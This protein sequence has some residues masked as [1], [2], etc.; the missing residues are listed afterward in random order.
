MGLT[1]LSCIVV[2]IGV[3][4]CGLCI[5]LIGGGATKADMTPVLDGER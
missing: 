3:A 5:V 4:L 2:S 1:Q